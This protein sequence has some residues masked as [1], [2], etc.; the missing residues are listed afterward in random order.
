MRKKQSIRLLP[1]VTAFFVLTGCGNLQGNEEEIAATEKAA[2][3]AVEISMDQPEASLPAQ[4]QQNPYPAAEKKTVRIF[5][6]DRSEL[7]FRM[8][9]EYLEEQ[10]EN[11]G[12]EA[13]IYDAGLDPQ[14]Q[15]SALK[16]ACDLPTDLCVLVPLDER[17]VREAVWEIGESEIPLV[18]YDQ[19]LTNMGAAAFF[20]GFRDSDVEKALEEAELLEEAH[21]LELLEQEVQLTGDEEGMQDAP[22]EKELTEDTKQEEEV[23]ETETAEDLIPPLLG[24]DPETDTMLLRELTDGDRQALVYRDISEEGIVVL[25]LG[26]NLLRGVTPDAGLIPA[27]GWGFPCEYLDGEEGVRPAAFYLQPVLITTENTEEKL[28]VPGYYVMGSDGY[29]QPRTAE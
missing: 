13:V 19:P 2:P 11:A 29:L 20:V 24:E 17:E 1:W 3:S 21:Q 6:P 7:R 8:D 28:V 22:E 12:F 4:T 25:D 15:A 27:S 26:L 10:F 16:S 14:K 23:L 9:G 5:L 18:I